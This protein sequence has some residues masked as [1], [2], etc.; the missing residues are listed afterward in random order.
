MQQLIIVYI[1]ILS[2]N[3]GVVKEGKCPD[4][5]GIQNFDKMKVVM[6]KII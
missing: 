1:L 3:A 5:K 2:I 6:P 4:L